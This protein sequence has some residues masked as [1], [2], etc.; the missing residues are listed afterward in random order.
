MRLS[1]YLFF[2]QPLFYQFCI[3]PLGVTFGHLFLKII[4][5]SE[6]HSV[7]HWSG[8]PI[9]DRVC[10]AK[11]KSLFI[12]HPFCVPSTRLGTGNAPLRSEVGWEEWWEMRPESSRGYSEE[13]I[14]FHV[15][16]RQQDDHGRDLSRGTMVV[17][18]N[19]LDSLL[20]YWNCQN[21]E[22]GGGRVKR[23][24]ESRIDGTWSRPNK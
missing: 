23:S 14:V 2:L 12:F 11:L 15:F 10:Y 18:F 20:A 17:I 16:Y 6:L 1:C 13:G 4:G 9:L 19:A 24:Q 21:Q 8:K 3:F 5:G 7:P 22:R